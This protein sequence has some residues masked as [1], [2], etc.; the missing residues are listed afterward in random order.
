MITAAEAKYL[1]SFEER[2]RDAT[3]HLS[4]NINKL[5]FDEAKAGRDF[6]QQIA[7]TEVD[8]AALKQVATALEERGF[9]INSNE[10]DG[11]K[12]DLLGVLRVKIIWNQKQEEH[13]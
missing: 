9:A 10:G 2:V 13:E 7:T 8:K 1:S 12:D 4:S 6:I 5:I 3:M 11:A